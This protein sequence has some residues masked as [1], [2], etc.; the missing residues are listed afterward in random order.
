[1]AERIMA[2]ALDKGSAEPELA[3]DERGSSRS[4]SG[5]GRGNVG[6]GWQEVMVV[7]FLVL[8]VAGALKLRGRA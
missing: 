7:V 5:G 1:V 3:R 4:E 8:I 6:I 2:L